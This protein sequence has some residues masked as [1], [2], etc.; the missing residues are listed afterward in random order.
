MCRLAAYIG[1]EIPLESIVTAPTY[2]LLSQSKD[3]YESK[4]STNGDGFVIA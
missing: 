1:P 3:A 4:V 2:S